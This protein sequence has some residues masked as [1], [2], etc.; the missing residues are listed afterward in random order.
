[1]KLLR[2]CA[3]QLKTNEPLPWNVRNEPGH[4]LLGKGFVVCSQAQL[5]ALIERGVYVDADE[6]EAHEKARSIPRS[7]KNPFALWVDILRHTSHLLRN[8]K[9]NPQFAQDIGVLAVQIQGAMRD[10]VD[11]GTF[12]MVHG[13]PQGGYC[14]AHSMQTAFVASLA[15]T[16]FGWTDSERL[17]LVQAALTMNIAMIDTQNA[18]AQQ[19]TPLTPQ[20]RAEIAE[21]PLKGR[22]MLE[23]SKVTCQDWLQAVEQHHIT[24][25]GRGLPQDSSH[26]SQLACMIHYADVYLAKLSPRASRP[27]M[28]VNIAARELFLKAEGARNPYAAAIIKE[29]GIFPPG[30][31]VKLANG[32]T[33]VVLRPGERADTPLVH[34]LISGDGWVFPESLARD[35]ARP[36]FKIVAAVPRG[37]VLMRLDPRQLF[38]YPT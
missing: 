31:F 33:A 22:Q 35:T 30:S 13:D 34:S 26:L 3:D 5:D 12:E 32:D 28:P 37:N 11:A 29:M 20:Q 25:D 1:M 21:H 14:V 6:F 27:A 24:T 7:Q 23:Q 10:D 38:G 18:L 16:R 9:D 8:P 4:L 19:N 36:E 2:L 15:S 17:I